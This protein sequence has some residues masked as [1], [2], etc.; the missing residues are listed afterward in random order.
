MNK[1]GLEGL[2]KDRFTLGGDAAVAAGP[3]G[4]SAS[5]DTDLLLKAGI[6]SYSRSKGLFAGVALKGAIIMPD[7]DANHTYYG[8]PVD[9]KEVLLG[10]NIIPPASSK[11]LLNTLTKFSN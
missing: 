6:F 8:G 5:A 10:D 7:K 11:E 4:R 2:L 3:V 1:R 9:A